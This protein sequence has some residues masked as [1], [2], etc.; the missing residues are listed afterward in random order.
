MNWITFFII[1]FMLLGF[2]YVT[3]TVSEKM[4]EIVSTKNLRIETYSVTE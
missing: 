1:V 3:D 2:C 4:L